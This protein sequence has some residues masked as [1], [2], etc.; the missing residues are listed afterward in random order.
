MP[1]ALNCKLRDDAMPA[2]MALRAEHLSYIHD[3][4]DEILFGGPARGDDGV[5]QEMIILL[6]TDNRIE[7]EA[8]I[9]AE[10]YS[11]SG[12]VFREILIRPWSQV[13]PETSP[14][15]LQRAVM[16]ERSKPTD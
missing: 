2:L 3:H 9:H 7:A 4:S 16:A 15:A 10:P 11:A 13:I 12:K 1:F 14:G 6:R 8:F 5:P